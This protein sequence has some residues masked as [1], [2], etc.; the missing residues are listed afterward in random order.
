MT[1]GRRHV[2]GTVIDDATKNRGPRTRLA[3]VGGGLGASA[4]WKLPK[5][6]SRPH[7][8]PRDRRRTGVRRTAPGFGKR[9]ETFVTLAA[10]AER[11]RVAGKEPTK[12]TEELLA[13]A[14]SGWAKGKNGATPNP[15]GAWK[16]WSARELVLAYQR[17]ETMNERT[18]VLGRYRKNITLAPDE[19]SPR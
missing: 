14:V 13:T 19:L 17:A 7:A 1:P 16:L 5:A 11:E 2:A 3:A 4:T 18:A 10:Q 8:R 12:K 15:D 9:I 6:R